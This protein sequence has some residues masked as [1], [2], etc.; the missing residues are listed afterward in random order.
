MNPTAT[1]ARTVHPRYFWH[2][3]AHRAGIDGARLRGAS[4][5]PLGWIVDVRLVAPW[6]VARL[7]IH[8]EVLASV[9][10]AARVRVVADDYRAD[11]ATVYIDNKPSAPSVDYPCAWHIGGYPAGSALPLGVTD[12]GTPLHLQ[13][14]GSSVLVGGNPGGG[15]STAL[16]VLLAGLSMQRNTI[17]VGIDPKSV[18]LAPWAARMSRLVIG[19]DPQQ[20]IDLLTSLVE[21]I[22]R[23]AD[24]M[25]QR[26][27]VTLQPCTEFP[28][29]VL[30]VDE[31]A[32]LGAN[33]TK[34][35]RQ[36]IDSLL[37][38]YVSLGRATACT[39]ILATQRPTSETVDP[40]TRSLVGY[41]L[42]MR[43]GDKWQA[44]AILGQGHH[45]PTGIPVSS[46][47]RAYFSDGA[48]IT[49][50]QVYALPA[51]N[52]DQY[53]APALSVQWPPLPR[54]TRPLCERREDGSRIIRLPARNL[55]APHDSDGLL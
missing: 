27:M 55:L 3:A 16:R 39:A 51:E 52:I 31:W 41:R 47:G 42:A 30:V 29:M 43:C 38:R 48:T 5:S 50:V 22:H 34:Q 12:N 24:Q 45:E 17:I 2:I 8:A 7:T 44:E 10:G 13:L 37:R 11:R 53:S 15:K 54:L 28:L 1:L 23:R 14:F 46:P 49:G 9:L 21:E 40:G 36:E 33:G 18:E 20:T 35:Q 26:S 25:R 32:E 6:T 4:R 19:R